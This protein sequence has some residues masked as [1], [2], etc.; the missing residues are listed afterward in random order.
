ME[1]KRVE[2]AKIKTNIPNA[3]VLDGKLLR[4][5]MDRRESH[6][7]NWRIHIFFIGTVVGFLLTKIF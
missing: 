3:I 7:Q 6:H 5:S 4:Q 2:I 1:Q